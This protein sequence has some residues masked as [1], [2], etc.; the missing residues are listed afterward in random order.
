[1]D[2]QTQDRDPNV[3]PQNFQMGPELPTQ[4]SKH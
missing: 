3:G 4:V 2:S 1:M